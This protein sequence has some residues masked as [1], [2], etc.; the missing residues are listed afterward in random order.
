MLTIEKTDLSFLFNL[1]V[2]IYFFLP[3]HKGQNFVVMSNRTHG[4]RLPRFVLN[5]WGKSVG[6][7][8]FGCW[9]Q[10]LVTVLHQV[11]EFYLQ[12]F[13]LNGLLLIVNG[14]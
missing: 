12:K 5:F 2:L 9:L 13:V 3:Y 11:E 10:L 6:L 4:R 7:L 14:F 8:P 1:Y